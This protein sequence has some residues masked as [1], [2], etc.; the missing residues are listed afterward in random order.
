MEIDGAG[1]RK[2]S[3]NERESLAA[4]YKKWKT[5]I[6]KKVILKNWKG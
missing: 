6:I 2:L 1:K 4:V 5:N 3:E